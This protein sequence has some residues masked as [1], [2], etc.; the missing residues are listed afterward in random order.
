MKKLMVMTRSFSQS[1]KQMPPSVPSPR[2]TLVFFQVFSSLIIP[3]LLFGGKWNNSAHFADRKWN[4]S[5][6]VGGVAW[7]SCL[8]LCSP[9]VLPG[10]LWK[11]WYFSPAR[12][13]ALTLPLR[14][15]DSHQAFGLLQGLGNGRNSCSDHAPALTSLLPTQ[16][17]SSHVFLALFCQMLPFTLFCTGAAEGFSLK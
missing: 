9:P 4:Q 13:T 15:S 6:D 17:L 7:V 8:P 1:L 12:A 14:L 2:Q 10:F 16:D 5:C 11:L 3:F